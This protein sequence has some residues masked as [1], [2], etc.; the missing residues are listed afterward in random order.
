MTLRRKMRKQ[1][2]K[3]IEVDNLWGRQFCSCFGLRRS[4]LCHDITL[5]HMKTSKCHTV[6]SPLAP[7][8]PP[9]HASCVSLI[10]NPLILCSLLRTKEPQE[11]VGRL[12]ANKL[13]SPICFRF[14]LTL[15]KSPGCI[16]F[17]YTITITPGHLSVDW[18]CL[19]EL[20]MI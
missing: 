8:T 1:Q 18:C 3:T 17:F 20:I 10:S 7:L 14:R 12:P 13:Q 11:E 5:S 19:D 4:A 6:T 9:P 2:L 15:N 16:T